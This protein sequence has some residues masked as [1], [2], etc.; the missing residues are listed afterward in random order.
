MLAAP[1]NVLD[2][3]LIQ[4][5]IDA[6]AVGSTVK[7]P[8]G[9]LLGRLI[10]NKPL[11]LEGAGAGRTIVDAERRGSVLAIDA[12]KGAVR[13][14]NL[15]LTGGLAL[16][17][18]AV[19]VDNGALATL[20]DCELIDN[21]ASRLGGAVHVDRGSIRLERTKVLRNKAQRGG[22]IF[23]A[24]DAKAEVINS[25]VAE[26][27]AQRGGGIFV[28]DAAELRIEGSTLERNGAAQGAHLATHGTDARAPRITLIDVTFGAKTSGETA[29]HNDPSFPASFL[30]EA[31]VWPTDSVQPKKRRAL[32][33]KN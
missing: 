20:V 14:S 6:A 19:S 2:A 30:S 4:R 9:R 29:I 26:S 23:V 18:G 5:Q 15:T 25:V 3:T 7:L 11:T 16:L 27:T 31:T 10:I 13:I 17:G 24:G 22:S 12:P 28:A 32:N 8:A 21:E 1:M 33:L